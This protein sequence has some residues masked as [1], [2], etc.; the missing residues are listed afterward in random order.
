MIF[1]WFPKKRCTTFLAALL[2]QGSLCF[3]PLTNVG[4][5]IRDLWFKNNSET[6]L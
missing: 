6:L 1:L 3:Y 2:R 4:L 5:L